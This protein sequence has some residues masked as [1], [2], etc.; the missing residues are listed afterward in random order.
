MVAEARMR[1]KRLENQLKFEAKLQKLEVQPLPLA[2][3]ANISIL[4]PII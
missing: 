4:A 1:Q 2:S 3:R